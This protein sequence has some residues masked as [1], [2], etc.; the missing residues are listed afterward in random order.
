MSSLCDC[1]Y[2]MEIYVLAMSA[3]KYN[4]QNHTVMHV[5]KYLWH[6]AKSDLGALYSLKSTEA[7]FRFMPIWWN[8]FVNLL[9]LFQQIKKILILESQN[10]CICLWKSRKVRRAHSQSC[11]CSFGVQSCEYSFGSAALSH[12][13]PAGCQVHLCNSIWWVQAAF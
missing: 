11:R 3:L 5:L 13:A 6:G 10:S 7:F 9:Y 4:M 2:Q 1:F 8:I 12:Q